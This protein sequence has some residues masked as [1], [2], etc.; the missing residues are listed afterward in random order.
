ML[1]PIRPLQPSPTVTAVSVQDGTFRVESGLEG[2]YRFSIV[3]LRDN[4]Y[5]SEAWLDGVR[6]TNGVLGFS[7]NAQSE[8]N[9]TLSPGGEVQGVVLDKQGQPVKQAQGILVSDPL[10]EPIPFYATVTANGAAQ[11]NAH[12]V[13]PGNYKLY[14]WEHIEPS[15]FFD[16]ELLT[17]SAPKATRVRV[18]KG[19]STS[20]SAK[21]IENE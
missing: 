2:R 20:V 21:I 15:Q 16:R 9:F 8:L 11:F 12:G 18:E 10:L 13:P 19:S 7:K 4:Y 14:F 5:V 3:P 1:R 6:I 17:R